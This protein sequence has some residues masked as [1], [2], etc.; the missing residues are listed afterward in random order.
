M[1]NPVPHDAAQTIGTVLDYKTAERDAVHVALLPV[2]TR[3]EALYPGCPI[4]V[5]GVDYEVGDD[6]DKRAFYRVRS[7][8]YSG[9]DRAHGVVDAFL[10]APASVGQVFYMMLKPGTVTSL[11]HAWVHPGV[12]EIAPKPPETEPQPP[13]LKDKAEAEAWLRD[14]CEMHSDVGF[15]NLMAAVGHAYDIKE[16]TDQTGGYTLDSDDVRVRI[17]GNYMHFNGTDAHGH[18][19][20][21]LWVQLEKLTGRRFKNPPEHF[22]CSC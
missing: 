2:V 11:R 5:V 16:L 12:P 19:D 8:G 17:D 15:E 3:E 10:T 18:I 7:A 1:S 4:E 22:S 21:E 14:W 13:T 20:P 9:R 6:G